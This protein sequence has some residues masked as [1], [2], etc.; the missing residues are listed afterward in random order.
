MKRH[1][2]KLAAALSA[3]ALG[4]VLVGP[5]A[6]AASSPPPRVQ[7]GQLSGPEAGPEGTQQYWLEVTAA[8]RDGIVNEITVEVTGG[9][10]NGIVFADRPCFMFPS[11]PGETITMRIPLNLPGPGSYRVRA[12][13]DSISSCGSSET[14]EGPA[15]Q[16]RFRVAG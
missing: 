3:C 12:H 1:G 10:Y 15:R 9:N 13:A 14:Q 4:A 2:T 7:I 8:D 11:N 6:G 16:R 5:P